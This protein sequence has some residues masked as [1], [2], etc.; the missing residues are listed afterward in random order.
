MLLLVYFEANISKLNVNAKIDNYIFNVI[1]KKINKKKHLMQ[2][3]FS[4]VDSIFQT[5][6]GGTTIYLHQAAKQSK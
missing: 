6:L 2:L 4:T 3:A 5:I 1:K